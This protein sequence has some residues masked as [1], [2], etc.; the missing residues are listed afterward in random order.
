MA[1]DADQ[2]LTDAPVR[3]GRAFRELR[4]GT[5]MAILAER[6]FRKPGEP[7]AIEPA[8]LD[9]LDLLASRDRRRMS[10][11]AAALRVDPSTVTRTLQRMEAAGVA[12]RG[13]AA[14]DGRVVTV[15]LTDA[16]RRL[17]RAVADRR[18]TMLVEVL[19]AFS[20][21]ERDQLVSLVERFIIS[22]EDYAARVDRE[23]TDVSG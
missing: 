3:I 6:L 14:A 9:V 18:T 23:R 12:R 22:L 11:L 4:R 17:H 7:D 1:A 2:A 10:E 15:R 13:P 8:Q 19:D 16:G 21:A 20:P 5:A